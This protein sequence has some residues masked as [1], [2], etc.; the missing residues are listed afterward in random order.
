MAN[1]GYPPNFS[2]S[3][4]F[5]EVVSFH[6]RHPTAITCFH[7][8]VYRDSDEKDFFDEYKRRVEQVSKLE[9]SSRPVSGGT[10]GARDIVLGSMKIEVINGSIADEQTEVIVNS[11]SVDM[12]KDAN[13]ITKAIHEKAMACFFLMVS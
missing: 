12:K 11:T 4:L 7:F 5:E 2:A 9:T 10:S 1:L 3:I 13:Q 8:V 6:Y